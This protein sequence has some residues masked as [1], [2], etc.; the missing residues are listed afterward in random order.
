MDATRR[1]VHDYPRLS[2]EERDRRWNNVRGLLERTDVDVLIALGD[3][4]NVGPPSW[5]PDAYLTG[6][7]PGHAVLFPLEGDPIAHVW[8][9]NAL[10]DHREAIR[11]GDEVWMQPSQF[12]LGNTSEPLIASLGEL[13]YAKATIGLVNVH[14]AWPYYPEGSISWVTLDEMKKALPEATFK[15]VGVE[16]QELTYVRSA[17]EIECLRK[18]AAAGEAMCE[19]ALDVIGPGVNEAEVYAELS[20]AAIRTGC[21][22]TWMVMATGPDP[23]TWGPPS[24]TYR[25]QP[26]KILE[27]GDIILC[28]LFPKYGMFDTQAQLAVTIGDVHPDFERAADAV[29]AGYDAAIRSMKPGTLFG[30]LSDAIEAPILEAGGWRLTPCIHTLPIFAAS[31]HGI[32]GQLIEEMTAY[33]PFPIERAHHL[34]ELVLRPGHVF[35]VQP[36][37]VFGRRRVNIGG[38]VIITE[39]GCEELN[40]LTNSLLHV[41]G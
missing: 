29:K 11:N 24:W 33:P 2:L 32:K 23:L 6:E 5:N 14:K 26:P 9:T 12:R 19:A 39:D 37:C 38:T 7:R 25:P 21:T 40:H 27:S 3:D 17:E 41:D 34:S 36:N 31:G 28:E 8:N 30:D 22:S 4:D 10:A 1:G 35:A 20:A 16:F 18:A 13:G 15:D